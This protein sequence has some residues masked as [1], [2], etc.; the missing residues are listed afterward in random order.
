[1]MNTLVNLVGSLKII[2]ASVIAT[3][4]RLDVYDKQCSSS[5]H[6]SPKN[7]KSSSDRSPKNT[8][9]ASI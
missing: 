7:T 4:E 1:M 6:R 8:K 3:L 5:S 9:R 2:N